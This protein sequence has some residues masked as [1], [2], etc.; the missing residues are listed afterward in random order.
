MNA[1]RPSAIPVV[2]LLLALLAAPLYVVSANGGR[3]GAVLLTAA[4]GGTVLCLV[5][6]YLS[7]PSRYET[8][9]PSG[10]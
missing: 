8:D 7:S 6:A 4:V 5:C 2:L 9:D 3:S 1:A 10:P